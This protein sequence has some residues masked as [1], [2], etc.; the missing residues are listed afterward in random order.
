M[1]TLIIVE[2]PNKCA[3]IK[4]YLGS[5]K[6]NTYTV[7]A[8]VGHIRDLQKSGGIEIENKF[9]ANWENSPDKK[10]VIAGLKKAYKEADDVV[11][12]T[13][14]DGEG[15][16]IGF[17]IC[18]VLGIDPKKVKRS[19]ALEI[20]QKAVQDAIK[21]TGK[22]DMNVVDAA[23]GRRLLDRLFGFKLSPVLWSKVK[24][25]LS[26]GRVQSPALRI[27]CTREEE[28][29]AFTAEAEYKVVG[30]FEVKDK[31]NKIQTFTAVLNKKFKTKKDAEDF[32]NKLI[33]K[34]FSIKSVEKKV[35]K[36]SAPAP[37]TTSA[38]QME[39]SRKLGMSPK[40]S[41]DVAQSL[42][43]SGKIS[44]HRTDSISLSDDSLNAAEKIVKDQFGKEYSNRKQFVTKNKSAQGA[45]EAIRPT[46]FE[47]STISGSIDDQRLYELIYK[48]TLASQM[49][50]AKVDNTIVTIDTPG[51]SE[52]FV[53][54]GQVITFDGFLN[55][56]MESVED[57][58][59]DEDDDNKTLPDMEKG[60]NL[61]YIKITAGQLYNKPAA[62]YSEASLVK[63]LEN[64]GIGR[65]STYASI[66][67][68][69]QAREYCEIKEVPAKKRN[70]TTIT[71]QNNKIEEEIRSENY[72]GD[73]NKLIP[74]DMGMIVN[75]FLCENF[76]EMISY[77]FTAK[78]ETNLDMIAEGKLDKETMLE[79]FYTPFSENVKK[80][81]GSAERAGIRQLGVDPKTNKPVFARL[82]KFGAMVQ[83]GES[84]K[85]EK[86][87]KEDKPKTAK[88]KTKAAPKEKAEKPKSDVK[89]A[90]IPE[91]KS[92]DTITLEEAL[93]LLALPKSLGEHKGKEVLSNKGPYGPYV[94]YNGKFYSITQDPSLVTLEEA[95]EAIKLKDEGGGG[96]G[97]IKEFEKGEMRVLDGKFGPYITYKKANYKIPS[98][99]TVS[100]LTKEDCLSI[101]ETSKS[102]P[103]KK[104]VKYKKKK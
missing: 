98:H 8:S 50:D 77:D 97:A 104:F 42:F 6:N 83:L 59:G 63:E 74:T 89:F 38:L 60:Q 10:D 71:L 80:V 58:E 96:K 69:I 7:M 2:S 68:V 91:G 72:G 13:D 76:P 39:A 34:D 26:A 22:L 43:A 67:S 35:G 27:I 36:K 61:K 45:H 18:E 79:N 52:Y 57:K 23:I 9:K 4:K 24:M 56:Y 40:R 51:I 90:S 11:I 5:D 88:G 66:I 49:A 64:L 16:A 78:M 47:E 31:K 3:S 33:Q 100:D 102:T 14:G 86:V 54:R 12:M 73:K 87:A 103:K 21:N 32:L 37:F 94:K 28:H 20:T 85:P 30:T 25:G 19:I 84:V 17:H 81:Q 70:I 75:K 82:G 55:L 41:M 29:R 48:R 62:R 95:I 44:Y 92:I 101:I 1:H 46:H 93:T 53:A 15:S 65:P 99:Y